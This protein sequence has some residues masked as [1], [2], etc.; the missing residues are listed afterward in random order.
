MFHDE[1]PDFDCSAPTRPRATATQ[2]AARLDEEELLGT[3]L[4]GRYRLLHRLGAGGMGVV[5]AAEHVKLRTRVAVK[6][7]KRQHGEPYDTHQRRFL[8]EAQSAAMVRHP[9]IV[10]IMDFGQTED[11]VVYFVMEHIEGRDL[12]RLI[13]EE[14]RI[15]WSRARGI[16]LQVA[17]GLEAAHQHR[18][19]HRDVKPSNCIVFDGGEPANE[20]RVKVLDFGIAK[21]EDGTAQALTSTNQVFGTA[22]YM[23]PELAEG[24][25]AN[26]ASDIYALGVM[27]FQM[28]T[29]ELPFRG[30]TPLKVLTMHI[31]EQPPRPRAIEPSIPVKVETI[32]LRCMAKPPGERFQRMADVIAALRD[33]DQRTLVAAERDSQGPETNIDAAFWRMARELVDVLARVAYDSEVARTIAKRAGFPPEHL[34]EFKTPIG[35]WSNVV[36]QATSGRIGLNALVGEAVKQFP[37]NAELCE[38]YERVNGTPVPVRARPLTMLASLDES[39]ARA[40]QEPIQTVSTS[41]DPPNRLGG[42]ADVVIHPSVPSPRIHRSPKSRAVAVLGFVSLVVGAIP[43]S[44]SSLRSWLRDESVLATTG[45]HAWSAALTR[46]SGP[47]RPATERREDVDVAVAFTRPVEV[48]ENLDAGWDSTSGTIETHEGGSTT[49]MITDDRVDGDVAGPRDGEAPAQGVGPAPTTGAHRR[50][51]SSRAPKVVAGEVDVET[52]MKAAVRRQCNSLTTK[53]TK[54]SVRIPVGSSDRPLSVTVTGGS[55]ELN[56]CARELLRKQELKGMSYR[57]ISFELEI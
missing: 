37:Y 12:T 40:V 16:I 18:I 23:A 57:V 56:V 8:R 50:S 21:L 22:G 51:G 30:P 14:G 27:M 42:L 45:D 7:L 4:D 36:E 1:Q 24:K 46:N 35:F 33:V 2:A 26:A 47:E 3:V 15:P 13:E 49:L 41:S 10:Q 29:G 38:C 55:E 53:G 9:N 34:H 31:T 11:D 54:L 43:W 32:V 17:S 19:I 28:L 39:N 6:V 44:L 25:P 48:T 52:R 20:E 5:Y